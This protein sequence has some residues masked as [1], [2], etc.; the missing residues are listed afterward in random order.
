YEKMQN[1][2]PTTN[3][4]QDL[5]ITP[6]LK[7]LTAQLVATSESYSQP[8]PIS[9][10]IT[11]N[12]L[13]KSI[14]HRLSPEL[15][16]KVYKKVLGSGHA[17]HL[18]SIRNTH[19]FKMLEKSPKQYIYFAPRAALLGTCRQIYLEA[20]DLLYQKHLFV[21]KC[22][23]VL[24]MFKIN[25]NPQQF[26][27]IRHIRFEYTTVS[28]KF[29][30]A[31]IWDDF[32]TAI[33]DVGHLQS[34]YVDIAYL[35]STTTAIGSEYYN[36]RSILDP[37]LALGDLRDV[38]LDFDIDFCLYHAGNYY[39][40][41]ADPYIVELIEKI[42]KMGRGSR[43]FTE[44]DR[45]AMRV[46]DG[47][48]RKCVEKFDRDLSPPHDPPSGKVNSACSIPRKHVPEPPTKSGFTVIG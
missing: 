33:A 24:D 36:L 27:R 22:P 39:H 29:E 9:D 46:A 16:Q 15:R 13:Q 34:L 31:E 48:G 14:L 21:F 41:D 43:T 4:G 44:P 20:V 8:P 12:S 2:D 37:L 45:K 10:I 1:Q 5:Q 47:Q 40:Y 38:D 35:V 23:K 30:R 28:F 7:I 17:I 19:K 26:N 42:Q 11:S 32:W 25:V 6:R 3:N 18:Q